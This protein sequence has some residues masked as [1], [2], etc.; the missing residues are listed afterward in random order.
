MTYRITATAIAAALAASAALAQ[1]RTV[2]IASW[3]GSYQEAQSK[4]LF[5]P[6]AEATGIEVNEVT[7]GGMSDVRLQVQT[8]A[9]TYDIVASGSGSA[10]R[11][12]EEGLLQKLDYD[13]IDVSN[14]YPNLY[15]DYCVGGDVFSTVYAWNTNTYGADGPQSW[16]DFWDVEAYPGRR[17]AGVWEIIIPRRG[18]KMGKPDC[19]RCWWSGCGSRR[20][21]ASGSA[22]PA[23]TRPAPPARQYAAPSG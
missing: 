14:F 7:Y 19:R 11:A 15:T 12:A 10:A 9:V 5:E 6:A 20:G 3:G 21:L 23:P 4:A 17:S 18:Y 2:T 16:A 1:E 22:S 8:G 13:V